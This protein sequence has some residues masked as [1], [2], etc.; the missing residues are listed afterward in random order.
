MG[1]PGRDPLPDTLEAARQEVRRL[2][3][4]VERLQELIAEDYGLPWKDYPDVVGAV[5]RELS[6]RSMPAVARALV[7]VVQGALRKRL[8]QEAARG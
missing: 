1:I 4:E 6:A 7:G 5:A 3:D 2:R 8:R